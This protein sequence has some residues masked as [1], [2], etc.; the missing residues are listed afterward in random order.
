MGTEPICL[1][2]GLGPVETLLNIIIEPNSLC[3]GIGIGLGI[4]VGQCKWAVRGCNVLFVLTLVYFASGRSTG[5]AKGKGG[6][7][8]MYNH[9]FYG[10]NGIVGAQ[11]RII[12]ARGCGAY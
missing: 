7:M 8:H 5:C 12:G 3:L 11:V 4:G 9:N 10:G 6:S 2:L 1:G